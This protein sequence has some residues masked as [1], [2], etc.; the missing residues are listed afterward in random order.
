MGLLNGM[1]E[2]NTKIPPKAMCMPEAKR[3]KI[4]HILIQ[5]PVED[6]QNEMTS[7]MHD[8]ACKL[9]WATCFAFRFRLDRC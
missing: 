3:I 1:I 4:S 2:D 7:T 9:H 5:T 6:T 8:G